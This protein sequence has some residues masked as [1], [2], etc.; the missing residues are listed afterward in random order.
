MTSFHSNDFRHALSS[1]AIGP[2]TLRNRIFVSA[3][4]P[5]FAENNRVGEKY[6]AYHRARAAGGVALQIT[7]C[8]AVHKSG[9][10][11]LSEDGLRSLDDGVI[12]GYKN[13]A[14]AIHDEGG[15]MLAQL[16]HSG[17][18]V[19][20]PQP[21]YASWSPSPVRSEITG[22]VSHAMSISEIAEVVEAFGQA[23]RRAVEGDLD[24]VEILSA[25]GY[26]PH[27]FLS[28]LTNR[29]TDQYGVSLAN[30]L[31]F[32]LEVI[33]RIHSETGSSRILGVR[34]PGDEFQP[35]GLTLDD[36]KEVAR[37]LDET[38]KVDYLNVIAHSNTG[39]TG[40]ALH[41]PPTPSKHGLF[42]P[43]AS[44]I[45]KVVDTPVFGI[46]RITSPAHANRIIENGDADMVGMTRAHLTDPDIVRKM[47]A[48]DAA[49]IRPCV[50]ANVCVAARFN[51]KPITCMHNPQLKMPGVEIKPT[52][53]PKHIVVVGAG[54]GGL[55]A[56]R[57][58]AERGHRLSLFEA[59]GKPGGQVNLWSAAP[60]TQELQAMIRWRLNELDILG[61]DIQVNT[62]VTTDLI[63]ELEPDVVI[64]A[65]GAKPLKEPVPGDASVA[66]IDAYRFIQNPVSTVRK[67]IVWSD[68]RG[69][70][71][72]V[73]AELL[74]EAGVET[75][76]ITSDIAI[77]ADLDPTVRTSWYQRFG[78]FGVRLGE[79]VV[80]D[81]VLA[82]G[83]TLRDVFT[84]HVEQRNNIDLIVDWRGLGSVDTL[85]EDL[86]VSKLN[87]YRI[88]DC[89]APRT[90]ELAT[91][92]AFDTARTL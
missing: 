69:Q 66:I 60:S 51:G 41:W 11:S 22:A 9:L 91:A 14:A 35:G 34:I 45:K 64:L 85:Y 67:A 62:P 59:T 21:G 29:R 58:A 75:E 36:M 30:R 88:G 2:F 63:T 37:I 46:G 18:C 92:E 24:G 8:T 54:P 87:V 61:V 49:R 26:L 16:G 47:Q 39:H 31:R 33:D 71:G 32:L 23:A 56:A 6:I 12:P 86:R 44:A 50:G 19:Y 57:I 77:A 55:E 84:G 1:L 90:L 73:A 25:F 10:L 52:T 17:G 3:H 89:V 53:Q 48:G 7:G 38:G 74:A 70:A 28:P 13:L 43:L 65:T 80:I 42:I 40:R 81:D 82:G 27:A 15:R 68:G 20:L 5:G 4:V 72:L 83:I 78:K 76:I 79:R